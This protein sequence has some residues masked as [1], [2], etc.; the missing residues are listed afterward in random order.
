MTTTQTATTPNFV[1]HDAEAL[2][3]RPL[4]ARQ[5]GA[6]AIVAGGL[7]VTA[8]LMMLPFDPKDHIRTSQS[9][10][11]QTAGAL[12]MGGF[13]ALM[14]VLIGAHGWQ[15]RRAGR[16]GV[17]AVTVALLGTMMLGGDLWFESFAVPWL[18]DGPAA[19]QV[20]DTDP[21]VVL[22]LGALTSYISFAVGWAMFGIASFRAAVFPR[23]I[24]LGIA[25]SG[26]IGFS[27]LL[28]PFGIPLGIAVAALGIWMMSNRPSDSRKLSQGD[29]LLGP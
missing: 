27:A 28:A 9:P 19:K 22:G 23:P 4:F 26:L 5:A 12:Y 2:E 17:V 15:A 18:A 7:I 24:S 8:Q 20:F 14:I 25:V 13:L 3:P 1:E 11:F 16:F 29:L 10:V 6:A 21:T